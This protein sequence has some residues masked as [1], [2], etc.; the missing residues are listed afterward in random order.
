MTCGEQ[1]GG[2]TGQSICQHILTTMACLVG[3]NAFRFLNEQNLLFFQNCFFYLLVLSLFNQ[4]SVGRALLDYR[5]KPTELLQFTS[6]EIAMKGF[7]Q[8]FHNNQSSGSSPSQFDNIDHVNN[9][10]STTPQFVSFSPDLAISTPEYHYS[11]PPSPQTPEILHPIE[12]TPTNPSF[13]AMT[14]PQLQ[15]LILNF[16]TTFPISNLFC[17]ILCLPEA[18]HH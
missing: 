10:N 16:H 1:Q 3:N 18:N 15:T 4:W 7:K 14:V 9:F 6:D 12:W 17:L 13:S 11:Y 2:L 5:Y 8:M